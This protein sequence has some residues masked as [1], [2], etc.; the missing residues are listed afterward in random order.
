MLRVKSKT[1]FGELLLK[2]RTVIALVMLLIVFGVLEPVFLSAF[3][4]ILVAK[5]V[6]LYTILGIGMTVVII[7]GGIDL[8]VGS[9]VGFIGM[10]A[11]GFIYEGIAIGDITIYPSVPTLVVICLIL[12]ALIGGVNGVLVSKLN[13]PPFIATLGSMYILRGFA[14]IRSGGLTFPNLAG[15]EVMGNTGFSWIGQ[16]T[17]LSLP[18]SVYFMVIIAVLMTIV[19]KKTPLGWHIFAIGGNERAAKMSGVKIEKTKVI[20]YMISGFCAAIVGLIAS[21]QLASAHPSTGE[22]W[23]MNAIAAAVLGG[24]SMS[25]GKGSVFGTV[26]GAF[27]I[28]VLNDGM[29]MLNVSEFWQMVIKGFVIIIAVIIDQSQRKLESR[30]VMKIQNQSSCKEK[31]ADE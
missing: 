29:V 10:M 2:G 14:M 3:S 4:L 30:R 7:S 12:G 11:G 23:E 21:S 5:H 9:M 18:V 31:K 8:S 27:V 13:V 28:G 16:G 6:S 20:V 17:W 1:S 22:T 15:N 24:T 25:G 19:F 26:I